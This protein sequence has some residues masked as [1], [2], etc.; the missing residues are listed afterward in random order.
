MRLDRDARAPNAPWEELARGDVLFVTPPIDRDRPR[1]EA[2]T[3]I[4]RAGRT[5]SR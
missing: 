3:R 5:E 1:I 2:A 4:D